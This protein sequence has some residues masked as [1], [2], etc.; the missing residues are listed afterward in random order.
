ADIW[1]IQECE[2]PERSNDNDYKSWAANHIWTG[3]TKNKGIG[4]FARPDIKLTLNDWSDNYKNHKVKHV[5]PCRVNDQ[6]DV[7]AVWLHS[8]KSPTFGYIG[9][10]WKYMQ[11]NKELM[12]NTMLLG[13]FNSNVKWD[14]WDRWWNHS[15]VIRELH[16]IGLESLYHKCFDE[17]QGAETRPTFHLQKNTKKPYHI[18]YIFGSKNVYDN[19]KSRIPSTNPVFQS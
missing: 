4:F 5:L 8:N 18:D 7:L 17:S 15:D 16:E 10:L 2:D 11:I 14:K 3:D 13:D 6:F 19:I 9:Q 1:V 12:T